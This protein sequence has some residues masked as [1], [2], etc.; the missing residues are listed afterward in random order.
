MRR[1]VHDFLKWFP[2]AIV[3]GG[4]AI[5]ALWT[6]AKDWIATEAIWA[7]SQMSDPWIAFF[8]VVSVAAYV[9]AIVWTG[10]ERKPKPS[11]PGVFLYGHGVEHLKVFSGAP[12]QAEAPFKTVFAP[13]TPRSQSPV[14]KRMLDV[15]YQKEDMERQTAAELERENRL[16]LQTRRRDQIA[17]LRDAAVGYGDGPDYAFRGHLEAVRAFAD[18]RGHLSEKFMTD[19]H[20]QRTSWSRAEGARYSYLVEIFLGELHRLEAEWKLV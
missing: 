10:Q 4:L 20:K 17:T 9:A 7:W 2:T 6:P 13:V 12:D 3:G 14:F 1:F 8:V 15:A 11:E 5:A 18:I 16:A 19:L